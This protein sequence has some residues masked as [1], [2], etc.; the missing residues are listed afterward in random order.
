M[1]GISYCIVFKNW[2]SEGTTYMKT[3]GEEDSQCA[4][5]KICITDTQGACYVQKCDA[6]ERNQFRTLMVRSE[7]PIRP[8]TNKQIHETTLTSLKFGEMRAQ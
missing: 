8:D 2:D 7:D 5:G 3:G 4:R 1:K 6:T